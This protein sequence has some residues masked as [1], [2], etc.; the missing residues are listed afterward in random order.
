MAMLGVVNAHQS[1]AIRPKTKVT[2]RI[3]VRMG[4]SLS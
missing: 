4:P 3:R 1:L 2:E